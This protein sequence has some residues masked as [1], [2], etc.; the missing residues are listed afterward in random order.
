[1][2]ATN[3]AKRDVARMET[4][5]EEALENN[6]I[7]EVD[8]DAIREL[9]DHEI[10]QMK[11]GDKSPY[12]IRN[13]GRKLMLWAKRCEAGLVEASEQDIAACLR[14]FRSGSHPDVKDSGIGVGNYQGVLRVFYRFHDDLGIDPNDH[15]HDNDTLKIDQH[16]GRKLSADDLLFREDIDK[17]LS[18]CARKSPRE[19][20][21]VALA[22]ATG[23]RIDAIRTLRLK[24][25]TDSGVT[26]DIQLNESEGQLKGASGSRPLLWAK[27]WVRPWV[28]NHPHKGNP[29]AA[30][31]CPLPDNNRNGGSTDPVTGETIRTNLSRRAS[32]AGL[33]KDIYPHL[34]RHTAITRMCQEGL[35]E[36]QIKQMV[37]WAKDSGQFDKY[38]NLSQD[39]NNDSMRESLG[40]PTSGEKVIIGKPSLSKC[41]IESCGEEYQPEAPKCPVCGGTPDTQDLDDV[42][43]NADTEKLLQKIA[44]TQGI[45]L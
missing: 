26:M 27:Y 34:F 8:Y 20:A 40:L 6:E 19:A 15:D 35:S 3:E 21:F 24:H 25:I 37:G 31:F 10:G 30:V 4:D 5:L 2:A 18:A 44:E 33:E 45:D 12:T 41:D 29:E 17:L 36:Q 43:E 16:K 42:V 23:Q 22:L 9:L 11:Q 14:G 32:E 28:N 7:A 1:M 38:N 39:L 13:H